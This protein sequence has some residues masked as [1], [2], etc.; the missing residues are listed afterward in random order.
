MTLV[1]S[2]FSFVL[3]FSNL[4]KREYN[5]SLQRDTKPSKTVLRK[6]K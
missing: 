2:F 5:Y 6:G 3:Q 4:H 1:K